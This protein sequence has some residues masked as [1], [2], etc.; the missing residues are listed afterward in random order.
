MPKHNSLATIEDD[1]F[2]RSIGAGDSPATRL[3][4]LHSIAIDNLKA[5]HAAQIGAKDAR[6]TVLAASE[7]NLFA[8][9]AR[10]DIVVGRLYMAAAALAMLVVWAYF[11]GHG[12]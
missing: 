3:M 4:E 12:C 5:E 1:R 7:K 11:R 2:L 6:I 8:E 9:V 10:L